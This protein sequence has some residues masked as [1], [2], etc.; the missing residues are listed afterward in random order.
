[1][2]DGRGKGVVDGGELVEM[3]REM[4]RGRGPG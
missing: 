1:M 2:G 3:E 4:D